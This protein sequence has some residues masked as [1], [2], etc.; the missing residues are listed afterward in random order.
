MRLWNILLVLMLLASLRLSA[1][2]ERDAVYLKNGEV[3][4]GEIEEHEYRGFNSPIEIRT[5]DGSVLT[6]PMEEVDMVKYAER[7]GAE[8]DTRRISIPEG[9]TSIGHS[10]FS[11]LTDLREIIIPNSVTSIGRDA[12]DRCTGL[13]E[14][15]IGERVASIGGYAFCECSALEKVTS[16]N[17]EPPTCGYA[18]FN[19]V[20]TK[21]CILYV[22]K[23][24]KAAYSTAKGWKSFRH[25]VEME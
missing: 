17:P 12:F 8:A 23:G 18:V 22:P 1:Q 7:E 19:G 25:I 13:V 11:Y 2:T 14:V 20:P 10:A 9:A 5:A 3:V 6:F 24:S 21:N 16:L 4:R 15:T